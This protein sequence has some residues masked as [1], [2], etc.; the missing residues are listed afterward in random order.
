VVDLDDVAFM[1]R[2]IDLH[3]LWRRGTLA[4]RAHVQGWFDA[5]T[6][7]VVAHGPFFESG[8]YEVLLDVHREDVKCA[9]VLLRVSYEAA[10]RRV[11]G[12]PGRELSKDP[13][14]LQATHDA[15]VSS[16]EQCQSL[17]SCSIPKPEQQTT[18]RPSSARQW[19][20]HGAAT[21][22]TVRARPPEAA[23]R[24]TVTCAVLA[25]QILRGVRTVRE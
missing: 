18:S 22:E 15:F 16:S 19:S 24:S 8:G 7:A 25:R 23:T 6:D 10:L 1:Q 9:H 14:F 2:E 4:A 12:D 13:E 17:T 20:A 3:K 5:E 21:V 11:S